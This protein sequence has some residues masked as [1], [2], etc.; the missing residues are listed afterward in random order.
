MADVETHCVEAHLL[1]SYCASA[2]Y[3]LA[4]LTCRPMLNGHYAIGCK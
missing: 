2:L 4:L 3:V 1:T